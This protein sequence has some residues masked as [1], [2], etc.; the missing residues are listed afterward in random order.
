M[1]ESVQEKKVAPRAKEKW[2]PRTKLH[3]K[4][5]Y[6]LYL[7]VLPA[8]III[9]LFNYVPM[10]GL[11]LAF[12]EFDP[13]LGI[14]G[15]EFVG[16]DYFR[17][18]IESYQFWDLMRNTFLIS[19][20][21]LLFGFPIPIIVALLFNQIRHAGGKKF[22]QTVSYMPHFISVIVVVGM[23]LIFLSPSS[24]LM[25]HLFGLFGL[26][27]INFMGNPDYFRS[28]YVA[29]DIWQHA[30]W[31]SIIYIAALAGV[32]PQLYEAAKVDGASRFQQIRNIEIPHLVPTIVIL[33]ILNAG[34][35]LGVG[36]EKIFLMQNS[37]NLPVSEV[38]E[39]YVYKVG[40]LSNQISYSTAI[41]LFNTMINFTILIVVNRIAKKTSE[42]SLW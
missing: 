13:S 11:Q 7:M 15:G 23:I 17:R 36:F 38:I 25:G 34:S 24:G 3:L 20:Y 9:L 42:T 37:M 6:Q 16:F 39:T 8:F 22:V 12:R 27:P 2:G 30:G 21:S 19:F 28:I 41:G 33:L 40:I 10:Y 4:N 35:L 31:N 26:E 14:T 29:S 32:N 1:L 18:F 5:N